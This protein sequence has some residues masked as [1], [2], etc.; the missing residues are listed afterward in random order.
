MPA[1][2]KSVPEDFL[3]EELPAYEPSG[4]GAHLFVTFEKRGLTTDEATGAIA[5]ALGVPRSEIGVAGMKDKIAVTTQTVSLPF[6][7]GLDEDVMRLELP[8]ILMKR[9]KRHGNKLKTGHLLGNRFVL[10][11]L[12]L[13]A[14]ERA[15]FVAALDR[16]GREG[17]PNAFG[18]QRFGRAGDNAARAR[19]WLS[20]EAPGPRDKRMA[21]LLFSSL[22]SEVFNQVLA[23][24]V[25]DGTWA[26]CLLGDVLK[27]H[28]SGGLFT[29]EDVATDQ[30]RAARGE[31]SATG[32]IFGV[33]MRKAEGAVGALEEEVIASVVGPKID[34]S[35]TSR[36]GEGTRRPLRLWVEA[37]EREEQGDSVR[38][39]F[40]LP[41]GAYATTVISAAAGG[42]VASGPEEETAAHTTEANE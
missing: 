4:E 21:R 35:K 2:I 29:C 26:S 14:T 28:D 23:R 6:R 19:A 18:E 3:V 12:G 13:D 33:K 40:V 27:K 31:I 24:R 36:L 17:V 25:A 42:K 34:L 1:R 9:A 20:G 5:R 16:I 7:P 37:L 32:P 41:K 30:A 15:S 39:A 11:V 38:V 10:R 22:Q 8:G